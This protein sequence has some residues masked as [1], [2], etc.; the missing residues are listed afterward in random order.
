MSKLGAWHS[1]AAQLMP[2]STPIWDAHTHTGQVDPDGFTNTIEEL[3]GAL[4]RVEH[5][6]AVLMTSRDPS[7]YS[8]ANDRILD[9]AAA[10]HGIFLPFL[11]VD[12]NADGAT[13]EVIRSLDRGHRGIKL[14][15]RGESFRLDHP[16]VAAVASIASDRRVPVLVHAGRGMPPLGRPVLDLLDANAGL[17]L[18]LAHCGLSDLAW[19]A[20]HAADYR[21]LLFDTAWWS[22][23]DL[24]A[25]FSWVDPSQ[26]LY[27][28]DTPYGSPEMS[29][30]VAMRSAVAA[31][32]SEDALKAVF[33][34]NLLGLMD[35]TLPSKKMGTGR[36]VSPP[37]SLI[38]VTTYLAGAIAGI[39]GGGETA[40]SIQL[41]IRACEL[42]SPGDEDV[43]RAI[44]ATLKEVESVG[45][46]RQALDLLVVCASAALTP[47]VAVPSL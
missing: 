35:G 20:P 37:V 42:S 26:I 27:A 44:L 34:G 9:E 3:A 17:R 36:Y 47:S 1:A 45:S 14:H 19:I 39:L 24:A 23:A 46:R 30:T 22:A 16:V 21:G 40:Q 5:A 25:L 15:P 7:G 13:D 8:K 32:L 11:R 2:V 31:G 18:I 6:G 28:S 12:P 43:H 38:R 4:A 29:F 10:S 41:A 33:G